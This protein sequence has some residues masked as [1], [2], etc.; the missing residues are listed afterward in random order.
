M[1]EGKTRVHLDFNTPQAAAGFVGW[2]QGMEKL[3]GAGVDVV[4]MTEADSP[5][6]SEVIHQ[7]LVVPQ[8]TESHGESLFELV[9]TPEPVVEPVPPMPEPTHGL[10]PPTSASPF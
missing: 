6:A 8:R 7:F 1:I 4:R 10:K 3:P 9:R 5:E 2:L